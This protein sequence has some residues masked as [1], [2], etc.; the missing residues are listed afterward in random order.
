MQL[1]LANIARRPR[2]LVLAS[3]FL[4]PTAGEPASAEASVFS[5]SFLGHQDSEASVGEGFDIL[6]K[7]RMRLQWPERL[8]AA[9][10]VCGSGK[11]HDSWAELACQTYMKGM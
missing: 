11:S 8:S 2:N 5:F 9:M 1:A 6:A 4:L 10:V 3:Y 7:I